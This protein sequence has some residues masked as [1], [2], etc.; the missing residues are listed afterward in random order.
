MTSTEKQPIILTE[1]YYLRIRAPY[2]VGMCVSAL[3][4]RQ[5]LVT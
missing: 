3:L 2:L 4:W 1:M 5:L